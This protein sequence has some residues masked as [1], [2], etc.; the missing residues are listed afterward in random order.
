M[1][2]PFVEQPNLLS[3]SSAPP[4]SAAASASA[5]AWARLRTPFAAASASAASRVLA[6]PA[7]AASSQHQRRQRRRRRQRRGR[8]DA[9]HRRRHGMGALTH[10][11]RSSIGVGN[12][13]GAL[14]HPIRRG[15]SVGSDQGAQRHPATK[16]PSGNVMGTLTRSI[17]RGIGVGH[18]LGAS[19]PSI[20]RS[21]IFS[22]FCTH[23]QRRAHI[24]GL[25]SG[26]MGRASQLVIQLAAL[27]AHELIPVRRGASQTR[28]RSSRESTQFGASASCSSQRGLA[29][30]GAHRGGKMGTVRRAHGNL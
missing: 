24:S 13:M 17:C 22:L 11:I 20:R 18:A 8:V 2:L 1:R 4:A 19:T 3:A 9:P 25:I 29:I 15:I 21:V 12:E 16:A 23:H 6:S 5:T 7:S 14:T 26:E 10:P 28:S 30:A 27:S